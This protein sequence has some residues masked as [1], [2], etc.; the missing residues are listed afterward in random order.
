MSLRIFDHFQVGPLA[1]NC[2][3]V[4]DPNAREAIVIDPGG[5]AGARR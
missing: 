3:I 1:C 5:D 4:G 2:Y